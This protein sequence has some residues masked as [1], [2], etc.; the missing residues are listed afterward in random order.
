M[1]RAS[2]QTFG[3]VF[4]DIAVDY[5]RQRP[6]YPDQLIDYACQDAHLKSGD[7][8]LE[9]GCGSGQLTKALLERRLRVTALEPGDNLITIAETNLQGAGDVEFVHATFEGAKLPSACYKAVFSASAFHW[10]DPEVSWLKAADVLVPGG[11]IALLQHF[12]LREKRTAQD[13]DL[14]LA[15]LRKVDPESAA[16]WPQYF[17][18]NEI[19]SGV[20][21]RRGNLSEAWSW[22]GSFDLTRDYVGQLY[23]D[24]QLAA[25]PEMTEQT[26]EQIL[27]LLRTLSFYSRLSSKQRGAL[28]YEYMSIAERLGRPLRSSILSVVLTAHR[29]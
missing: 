9:V 15:A 18:L 16:Q 22:L 17:E 10:I 13:L 29:K 20:K 26:A 25:M 28:E 8:V 2:R 11:T 24:V 1:K 19:I 23:D 3:K 12:G 21:M 6:G 7:N 14:Q 5:D 27:R 4:D